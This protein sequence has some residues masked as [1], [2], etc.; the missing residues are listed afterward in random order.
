MPTLEQDQGACFPQASMLLSCSFEQNKGC[1][2]MVTSMLEYA[3]LK[4]RIRVHEEVQVASSV[5]ASRV[6]REGL[7]LWLN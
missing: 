6:V 1:I 5:H 4:D 3:W 7:Y 2:Q